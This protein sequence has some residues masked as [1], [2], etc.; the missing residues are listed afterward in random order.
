MT[1][2][3]LSIGFLGGANAA[4]LA[5]GLQ[6]TSTVDLALS[7]AASQ[8][9]GTDFFAMQQA[10]PTELRCRMD[11]LFAPRAVLMGRAR[12]QLAPGRSLPPFLAIYRKAPPRIKGQ[13]LRGEEKPVL[14]K[15]G[16]MD[17]HLSR[18]GLYAAD[19]ARALSVTEAT[20]SSWRHQICLMSAGV[21][22]VLKQAADKVDALE[23]LT[24]F[25]ANQT[26][27]YTLQHP[28]W[29]QVFDLHRILAAKHLTVSE[30]GENDFKK[31]GKLRG[32]RDLQAVIAIVKEDIPLAE[33][34]RKT[35]IVL[36]E[37]QRRVHLYRN[38]KANRVLKKAQT[39]FGLTGKDLAGLLGVSE[40]RYTTLA[41]GLDPVSPRWSGHVRALEEAAS[42]PE[43]KSRLGRLPP[44]RPVLAARGG[45]FSAAEAERG[46]KQYM[47]RWRGQVFG[48]IYA[49][50]NRY[51]LSSKANAEEIVQDVFA[52]LH[53]ALR[54][55]RL[56]EQ[57][58]HNWLYEV[59][60]HKVFDLV[61]AAR[62]IIRYEA[63]FYFRMRLFGIATAEDLI[64]RDDTLTLEE[65]EEHLRQYEEL[66]G[67]IRGL[68]VLFDD[69]PEALRRKI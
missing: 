56:P 29:E 67:R 60:R 59:V 58:L 57:E 54:R 10:A 68:E 66:K 51:G 9:E 23:K 17:R 11:A 41:N 13:I 40:G 18:L 65:A 30:L 16:E 8:A 1:Q 38:E 48:W 47:A 25:V 31:A 12:E 26:E 64:A 6:D 49:A 33:M 36:R 42:L 50:L 19:L 61:L 15:E 20:V 32:Q 43:L 3:L 24:A 27:E 37:T 62:G 22:P 46:L 21:L 63:N 2:V 5:A 28:Y 44:L 39:K 55:D 52:A 53:R 34:Q 7:Q 45:G 4:G 14:L 35:R 69:L